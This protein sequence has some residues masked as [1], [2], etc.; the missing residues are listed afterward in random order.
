MLRRVH[1]G[2]CYGVCTAAHA[3]ACALRGLLWPGSACRAQAAQLPG[4]RLLHPR[5]RLLTWRLP[6]CAAC[7]AAGE[8]SGLEHEV[9][10][11]VVESLKVGS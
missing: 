7:P 3:T 10:P 8:Y 11:G 1:S 4:R 2:P 6:P 9:V 5:K